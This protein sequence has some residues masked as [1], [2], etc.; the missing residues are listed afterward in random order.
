MAGKVIIDIE[1]CK[2]CELCISVCTKNG[3]VISK[4]SNKAGYFPAQSVNKGDCTGCAMCAI[5]CPEAIIEVYRDNSDI[6]EMENKLS[7][8]VAKPHRCESRS[9]KG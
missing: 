4:R 8:K 2:G 1:R 7:K 3:I 5:I 6:I 9:P